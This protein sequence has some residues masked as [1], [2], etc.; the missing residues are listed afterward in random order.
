MVT[1]RRFATSCLVSAVLC[2]SLILGFAPAAHA[3]V[4][5]SVGQEWLKAWVNPDASVDLV[6]NVS[7]MYLSG[8]PQGLFDLGMPN[9]NFQI[10]YVQDTSGFVLQY[11]DISRGNYAGIEITL[12]HPIALNQNITFVVSATVQ[13][14]IYPDSTNQGNYGLQLYPATF[15]SATGTENLRLEIE[16]PSVV[17]QDSVR[18][19]S[20]LQFDNVF[21]DENRTAVFWERA[22]WSPGEAV[23]AGVSF[24]PQ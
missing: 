20:G 14:M 6:Y 3:Q 4:T 12:K 24:P 2:V 15:Q 11:Q 9:A 23:V 1:P 5:Y 7:F 17:P 13:G 10:H 8:S 21:T 16:L 19:P 18:S 22:S